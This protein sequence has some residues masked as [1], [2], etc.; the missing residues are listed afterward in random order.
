MCC[1]SAFPLSILALG[2][3]LH[4]DGERVYITVPAWVEKG[5]TVAMYLL[6]KRLA[7]YPQPRYYELHMPGAIYIPLPTFICYLYVPFFNAMRVWARFSLISALAVA[8]LACIG[9]AR[10]MRDAKG[11]ETCSGW[12]AWL[13]WLS[14]ALMVFELVAMPHPLGW[15]EV[16]SQ[17]MDRWLA[18][19]AEGG[20]VAQFPLEESERDPSRLYATA[21][22]G[23]PFVHGYGSF[24]PRRYRQLRRILWDFPSV[25]AIDLLRDWDVRYVLVGANSY[26]AK[27]PDIWRRIEQFWE[28]HLVAI[29]DEEPCYHSGWL[30]EA[31]PDLAYGFMVDRVYV[32]ELR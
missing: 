32:Y 21:V 3:T 13:G 20:A 6:A 30:A 18:Q 4:I 23:R 15:T 26:G 17:P 27:W 16:R 5:F 22:H 28:L 10:I 29:F 12:R 11:D 8:V 9:L 2:T 1:F 7:F 14:L 25:Q 19:Q 31:W 24:F